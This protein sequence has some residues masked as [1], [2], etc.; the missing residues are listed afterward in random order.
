MITFEPQKLAFL[1]AIA[2]LLGCGRST[3]PASTPS[4]GWVQAA[5]PGPGAR[6]GH[7]GVLDSKR[8]QVVVFG[9]AGGGSEVWLFSLDAQTW[10]RVDAPNGPPG[11]ATAGAVADMSR[12]R[13]VLFGGTSTVFLNQVW[14]FSF[15]DHSWSSLPTGPSAR[16]D[17]GAATDGQRAWFYG[18]FLPGLIAVNEL[19]EFNLASN[20]W[21]MLPQGQ[22]LPSPRTNM[23]I[24]FFSGLLF[25]TGG[26]D[27]SNL[28]PGTWRFDLTTS[29]WSQLA[30]SGTQRA[31]A[32][33]GYDTDQTCGDLILAGGDHDDG[34]D[35][36][37]TDF[38][39]L[40]VSPHFGGLTAQTLPPPRRHTVLVLDSQ[41]RTLFMFGGLQGTSTALG[42]TW[43]YHLGPCPA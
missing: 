1:F 31:G 5:G 6:W 12:D 21:T 10:Q 11:I 41:T 3:P 38:L 23:A 43:L 19:W 35:I 7:V 17:V 4:T 27:T 40:S 33:F 24:G 39:T 20:S 15:A 30:P 13:M 18:G 37:T 42:D 9:G 8:R 29:S 36:A 32:H 2:L 25:M 28:T 16:F 34:I 26:H 14:A 22:I